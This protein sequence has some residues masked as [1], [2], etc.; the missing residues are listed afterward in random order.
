MKNYSPKYLTDEYIVLQDLKC[1]DKEIIVNK[2][3]QQISANIF[4]TNKQGNHQ[5]DRL[6]FT[7]DEIQEID[8]FIKPI[9]E[10]ENQM[11]SGFPVKEL[12]L[13][14]HA[15]RDSE[16]NITVEDVKK[17]ASNLDL[18]Y[19]KARKDLERMFKQQMRDITF[20]K[21]RTLL[22]YTDGVYQKTDFD[23]DEGIGKVKLEKEAKVNEKYKKR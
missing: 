20:S 1:K 14:A 3:K 19:Q 10:V 7:F 18:A 11:V 16:L 22:F 13:V 17:F 4:E 8:E 12:I 23:I 5:F 9:H 6:T 21:D 15:L 2:E